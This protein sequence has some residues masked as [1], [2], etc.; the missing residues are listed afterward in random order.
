MDPYH[1]LLADDHVL[2][3]EAISK[4]INETP[5]LEVIG[6][7][8]DGL[9][10]LAA[11]KKSVPDLVIL[12]LTMPHLSGLEAAKEILRTHPQVKIL[13]LTM[14]KSLSCLKGA[15]SLGVNGYLLKEDAFT[16]LISAI[17]AIREGKIY[18]SP[19]LLGLMTESSLHQ[20]PEETLSAQEIRI[21]S[22]ISQFKSDDEIAESL[23]ISIL[24][25][26]GHIFRIKKKLRI[27]TRP[28][29][30]KYARDLGLVGLGGLE[31]PA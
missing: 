16:N 21:L 25:L 1:I 17:K 31:D 30:I 27:K 26:R 20:Q 14:H 9:E 28:H 29:L 13:I 22:L 11:L 15:L 4:A 2:F 3:R 19:R 23:D 12:D 18:I 5:G 8:S 24:T 7:A 6:G 10:L